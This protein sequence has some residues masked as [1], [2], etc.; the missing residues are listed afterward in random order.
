MEKM[1]IE[2]YQGNGLGI[3]FVDIEKCNGAQQYFPTCIKAEIIEGLSKR[4]NVLVNPTGVNHS[5][6]PLS[7]SIPT[8]PDQIILQ[9][10][11]DHILPLLPTVPSFIHNIH[12]KLSIIPQCYVELSLPTIPGNMGKKTTE[13]IGT[14]KVDYTLYPNGTV[15]VEVRC[16]NNPFRLQTE[17]DRSSL[18]VF[19]GQI[20]Q[21]LISILSDSHERIVPNV[22]EWELTECDINKDVKVSGWFHYTGLKIQVKHMNHLFSIYI[23]SMG[24][25]TVYR[26]EERKHPH[27]PA[28]D[29]INDVF[30]PIE[31]FE[32]LVSEFRKELK[33]MK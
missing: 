29:F 5:S 30:N 26:I 10:L 1:A 27:K 2:R 8:N 22:L 7:S 24:K 28:L 21:E 31:K 23:K 20:R 18:L 32:K 4:R 6:N 33:Q 3:T 11:M 9:T 13:V 14:S 15:N 25:D 16:S 19:F 17:E 12:L